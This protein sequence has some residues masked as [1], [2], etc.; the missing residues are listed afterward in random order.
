[1]LPAIIK[2][3]VRT[4]CTKI[5]VLMMQIISSYLFVVSSWKDPKVYFQTFQTSLMWIIPH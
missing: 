5:K 2:Q 3:L 1:M 4:N